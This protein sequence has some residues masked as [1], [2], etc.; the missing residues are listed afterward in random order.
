M[1]IKA[2]HV[3]EI[4][5]EIDLFL[6]LVWFPLSFSHLILVSRRT[7]KTFYRLIF[8]YFCFPSPYEKSIF[9]TPVN[10][11]VIWLFQ[12]ISSFIFVELRGVLEWISC[13]NVPVEGRNIC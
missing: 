2:R 5:R 3:N 10:K 1:V 8:E 9:D 12:S 7:I 6:Y 4:H 13:Q 11:T